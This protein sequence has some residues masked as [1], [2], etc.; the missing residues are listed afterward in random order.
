V[1]AYLVAE[2][3]SHTLMIDDVARGENMI[4]VPDVGFPIGSGPV[5]GENVV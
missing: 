5:L 2:D 3:D 1:L 4:K